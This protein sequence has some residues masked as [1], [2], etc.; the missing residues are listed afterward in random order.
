MLLKSEKVSKKLTFSDLRVCCTLN[1]VMTRAAFKSYAGRRFPVPALG[2]P[3]V[4]QRTA[5][6][7]ILN[8][9]RKMHRARDEQVEHGHVGLL[10]IKPSIADKHAS[11]RIKWEVIKKHRMGKIAWEK[12]C[13]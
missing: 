1:K 2:P 9:T 11:C 6:A 7:C 12:D 4:I 8:D 3:I 13:V 5:S 10:K